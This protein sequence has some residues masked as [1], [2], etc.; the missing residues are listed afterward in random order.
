[1]RQRLLLVALAGVLCLPACGSETAESPETSGAATATASTPSA[2]ASPPAASDEVLV[3]VTIED[4]NVDPA[5]D[6]VQAA[7]GEPIS[8][9]ID[10][11][12]PGE[13]HVHSTPEHSIAI[14]P[15]RTEQTITIDQPGV[16]EVELHDPE[17]VVV[18]LEVR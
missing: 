3:E 10:S 14:E 4:G 15:G 5:G 16:V 9:V 17:V 1:M 18:Q 7:T 13:L 12:S 8:F 6:R 11:D 2:S